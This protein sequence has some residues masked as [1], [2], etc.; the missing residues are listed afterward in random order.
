MAGLSN[1]RKNFRFMLEL[2]GI[3]SFQIQEVQAPS[4]ELP[5]IIHGSTAN[6]PDKKTPGKLQVGDLVVKKLVYALTADSW[7]HNWMAQAMAG[8]AGGFMK[9]GFLKELGIDGITVVQSFFLGNCWPTKIERGNLVAQGNGENLIETVT[10]S[11]RK[12]VV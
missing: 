1:P 11:D 7:A 2:D 4:L 8:G 10:I 6:D 5:K 12:S 3:N 9:V